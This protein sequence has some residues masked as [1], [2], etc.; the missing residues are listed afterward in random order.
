MPNQHRI[1]GTC[2]TGFWAILMKQA[3][4]AR[5]NAS[6]MVCKQPPLID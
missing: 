5:N 6:I 4:Y 2:K 1:I 3:G